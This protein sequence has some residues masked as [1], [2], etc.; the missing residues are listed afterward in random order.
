MCANSALRIAYCTYCTYRTYSSSKQL[1]LHIQSNSFS[2]TI[3]PPRTITNVSTPCRFQATLWKNTFLC[4]NI[5]FPYTFSR[6]IKLSGSTIWQM[7]SIEVKTML[8][9]HSSIPL[10]VTPW[11]TNAYWSFNNDHRFIFISYDQNLMKKYKHEIDMMK[12][13]IQQTILCQISVWREGMGDYQRRSRRWVSQSLA[14][15]SIG[16]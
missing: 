3:L 5:P 15:C 11:L 7:G 14:I 4:K 8:C 2:A 9:V 16:G 10:R 12:T 6:A 1:R 13:Q